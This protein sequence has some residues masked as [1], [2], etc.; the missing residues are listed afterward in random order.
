MSAKQGKH[1]V[2]EP[3]A[4]IEPKIGQSGYAAIPAI[5]V[6]QIFRETVRKHAS[7]NAIAAKVKVNGVLSESWRFW[8][9]QQYWDE[10]VS[11][12]KSLIHLKV[13]NF[14]ARVSYIHHSSTLH[15]IS[16]KIC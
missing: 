13:T 4:Y 15:V 11:F 7:R 14:K 10:C 3:H 8:T 16:C 6:A 12:A 1:W 5:T 2:T 9:Y